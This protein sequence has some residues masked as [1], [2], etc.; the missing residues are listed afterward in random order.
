MLVASFLL[1]RDTEVV[2]CLPKCSVENIT[3][4]C[5]PNRRVNW[6]EYS[7]HDLLVSKNPVPGETSAASGR[8]AHLEDEAVIH[9]DGTTKYL[10]EKW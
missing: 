4:F 9:F 6:K 10:V 5:M 2:A 1:A 3:L 7:C 8:S